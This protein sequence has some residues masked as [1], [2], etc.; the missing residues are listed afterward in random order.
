MSDQPR[1]FA[2]D[3]DWE[4]LASL[5]AAFPDWRIDEVTGATTASLEKDWNPATATLRP[6]PARTST[7]T[8]ALISSTPSPSRSAVIGRSHSGKW[9]GT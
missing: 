1:V 6:L 3:L 8:V 9:S 2:F 4:S 5:R 7:T